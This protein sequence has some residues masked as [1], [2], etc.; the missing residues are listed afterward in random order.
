MIAL[1]N[2]ASESGNESGEEQVLIQS[3]TGES[4]HGDRN[5]IRPCHRSA[6][7]NAETPMSLLLY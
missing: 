1:K 3:I 7:R 4:G 2:R 6:G 5:S